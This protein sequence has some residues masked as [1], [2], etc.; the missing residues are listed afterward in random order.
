MLNRAKKVGFSALVVTLDMNSGYNPFL[1]SDKI[2]I[3]VGFTDPVFQE[4]F[5]KKY[6]VEVEHDEGAAAA[7]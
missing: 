2:G 6:G 4:Q 3:A 5:K 1:G 7:E